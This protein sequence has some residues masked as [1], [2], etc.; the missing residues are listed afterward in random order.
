MTDEC[1]T[2]TLEL[3]GQSQQVYSENLSK[4]NLKIHGNFSLKPTDKIYFNSSCTNKHQT[5]L[6][7]IY[8]FKPQPQYKFL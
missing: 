2:F 8:D 3:K 1:T 7:E 5:L 6:E 4:N